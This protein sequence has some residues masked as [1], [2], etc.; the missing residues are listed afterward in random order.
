VDAMDAV[1]HG[2][3]DGEWALIAS[4]DYYVDDARVLTAL[5]G[6]RHPAGPS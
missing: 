2:R 4:W 5:A 6:D 1:G 3:S